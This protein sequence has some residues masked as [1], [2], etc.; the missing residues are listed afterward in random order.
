MIDCILSI[1]HGVTEIAIGSFDDRHLKK[2]TNPIG[3]FVER[4]KFLKIF[5]LKDTRKSSVNRSSNFEIMTE[6]GSLTKGVNENIGEPNAGEQYHSLHSWTRYYEELSYASTEGQSK[7][8]DAVGDYGCIERP[9]G[10]PDLNVGSPLGKIL[11]DINLKP[12]IW[13]YP[14]YVKDSWSE[15]TEKDKIEFYKGSSSAAYRLNVE[16]EITEGAFGYFDMVRLKENS[17]D[18]TGLV[19]FFEVGKESFGNFE[20]S[21]IIERLPGAEQCYVAADLGFGAAPTEIIIVFFDGKKYKWVYNISLFRLSTEEQEE[22]FYWL[23]NKLGGAFIALDST[24]DNSAMIES[25]AKRGIP[26]PHLLAVRFNE[27]MEIGFEKDENNQVLCDSNGE[28]ITK[29]IGTEL[30]SFQELARLFYSGQMSMPP[31]EKF[32]SQ[33]TNVICKQTK[34]RPLFD[35]KIENH[36]IQSWQVWSVCRFYNEWV[37]L[38]NCSQKK[39]GWMA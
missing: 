28:P 5:Q 29:K 16:A 6:H 12:W 27:N 18:K 25:L 33:A 20:Q 23:Y 7:G 3:L 11:Q 39:R 21:L 1:I 15:Q 17:L 10:I 4:H 37:G 24:S 2:V 22:I 13:R 36:L 34:T 38:K 19:K 14:Q 35:C 31:D 8:I 9:S 26:R 30:F 32:L